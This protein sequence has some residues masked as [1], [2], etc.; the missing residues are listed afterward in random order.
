MLPAGSYHIDLAQPRMRLIKTLLAPHVDMDA[1]FVK[2]Q[3]RRYQQRKG[4]Q[5]YDVTAWCLPLMS[6]IEA[7][8]AAAPIPGDFEALE[9]P[10]AATGGVLG[11]PAK[12]AYLVPWGTLDASRACAA[13][14]R[15]GL[16]VHSA[17]KAFT[18]NDRDYA[19]GSLIVK[20]AGNP[21]DLHRQLEQISAETS[22]TIHTTDTSWVQK[23]INFGSNQVRFVPPPRIA[24]AWERPTS[25]Y[26]AGAAR[27]VLEHRLGVPVTIVSTERLARADLSSFTALVLP[28][29]SRRGGASYT[30]ALGEDGVA[31]IREWITSGGTLVALGGAT[32]WLAEE[33]VG[34]L[35]TKRVQREREGAD[36]EDATPSVS[37]DEE[38][39]LVPAAW[40][41]ESESPSAIPGALLRATLDPEHWIAAGYG[42]TRE[43]PAQL[44]VLVNSSNIF[45][46]L[47]IDR[48]ANV[49]LYHPPQSLLA[50][51]T[52]WPAERTLIAQ[53][54]FLMVQPLGSGHVVAFTEDP[55][56]RAYVEG[57]TQ[58]FINAVLLGP[59]H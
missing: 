37:G 56:F 29:A 4:D 54:P 3:M 42:G 10:P 59:A 17:D 48:G 21:D 7:Y 28:S 38:A 49:G 22:A 19:A 20:V 58:L 41:P 5:I 15:A 32:G 44:S 39:P 51:G 55:N 26:S 50:S 34:L 46:P 2:E 52:I 40:L 43:E 1:L 47:T 16:R 14:L 45:E 36:G 35:A 18:I 9:Q 6:G 33:E 53:K 30:R 13:M 11:D 23:G 27:F 31:A 12:V 57:M 24:L 8:L 25:A